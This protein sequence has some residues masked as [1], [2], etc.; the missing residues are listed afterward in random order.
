MACKFAAG[1]T[2]AGTF[3]EVQGNEL[4]YIIY[5]GTF[6]GSAGYGEEFVHGRHE[7]WSGQGRL[8]SRFEGLLNV[9]GAAPPFP[10]P[11]TGGPSAGGEYFRAYA[12][13]NNYTG[14]DAVAV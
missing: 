11:G 9:L 4:Y 8:W 5:K 1:G 13:A 2:F 14:V 7:A 3:Q 12:H 10:A 6:T